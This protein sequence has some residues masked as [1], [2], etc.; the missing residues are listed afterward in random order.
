MKTYVALAI[1]LIAGSCA[2]SPIG[3]FK[4][5]EGEKQ[6]V[7]RADKTEWRA[8][9]ENLPKGCQIAILEGDPQGEGIF[10]VRFKVDGD[11]EMPPHTHP[12]DERVTVIS[13][14]ALVAFGENA[15]REDAAQFGP[16]DYYIN[17]RNE[18]HYVWAEDGTILQITGIGPWKADFIE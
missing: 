5:E 12:Q 8:C 9:P 2:Q 17:A 3:Q 7:V 1:L 14:K 10:T 11:F 13:G 6:H 4:F 18:I 16:G 15:K